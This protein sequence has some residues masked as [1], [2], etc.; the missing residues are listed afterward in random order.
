MLETPNFCH[1]PSDQFWEVRLDYNIWPLIFNTAHHDDGSSCTH[2]PE[3][4]FSLFIWSCQLAFHEK[5]L[6]EKYFWGVEEGEGAGLK[7][8]NFP[9]LPFVVA[10]K[11]RTDPVHR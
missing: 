4:R 5:H 2:Q 8:V 6:L 1:Q 11:Y 9:G 3:G 7:V 10:F